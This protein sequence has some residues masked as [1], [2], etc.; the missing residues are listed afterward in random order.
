[1]DTTL[2][3]RRARGKHDDRA[4][5]LTTRI[6][7]AALERFAEDGIRRA[8]MNAIA[9]RAGVGVATVYRRFP[10]KEQ[11]VNG[12]LL[13]EVALMFAAVSSATA[14]AR[15][16]EDQL[17]DGF[18]SFTTE[19]SQRKL[20]REMFDSDHGLGGVFVSEHGSPVLDLGRGFLADI[21]RHW[22]SD[23]ELTDVD[24]DLVAEILARLAHSL[25]LTPGGL[26]PVNDPDKARHFARAYLVR[27]LTPPG[28]P[29]RPPR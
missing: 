19:I 17:V 28:S 7:D 24:A 2:G 12:V 8:T 26:I 1:M 29:S 9:E 27:L 4:D 11:L 14:D 25:A 18:V 20:L 16:A 15:T 6:L 23:N 21:I 13:R 22:Q 10:Q 3:N 5:E